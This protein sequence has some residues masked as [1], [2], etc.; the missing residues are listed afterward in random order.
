MDQRRDN[1]KWSIELKKNHVSI[2]IL[3]IVQ[4]EPKMAT[5]EKNQANFGHFYCLLI[6]PN[7]KHFVQRLHQSAVRCLPCCFMNMSRKA[8]THPT[9]YSGFSAVNLRCMI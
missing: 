9:L 4:K 8:K 2:F 1:E 7:L 5:Y 3:I 6:F